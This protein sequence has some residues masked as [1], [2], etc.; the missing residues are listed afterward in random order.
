M[1][2]DTQQQYVDQMQI[3]DSLVVNIYLVYHFDVSYK[4][5]CVLLLTTYTVITYQA[6]QDVIAQDNKQ[7]NN[8]GS[9]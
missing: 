3:E 1:Y 8:L 5:L 4:K 9:H 6:T 7:I 2:W